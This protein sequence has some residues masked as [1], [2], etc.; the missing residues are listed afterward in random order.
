M[1]IRT[2]N[3][4]AALYNYLMEVKPYHTKIR[5]MVINYTC[6]DIMN[7]SL[8][9]ALKSVYVHMSSIRHSKFVSPNEFGG[10]SEEYGVFSGIADGTD[11]YKTWKIPNP[12]V[13]ISSLVYDHKQ[14]MISSGVYSAPIY[15]PNTLQSID[16]TS[17]TRNTSYEIGSYVSTYALHVIG[18]MTFVSDK[19][20]IS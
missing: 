17:I 9:D 8:E 11:S 5:D 7:V 16:I 2:E 3:D 13:G 10:M 19:N 6:D 1:A 14:P 12:H 18:T 20:V 4:L 15:V